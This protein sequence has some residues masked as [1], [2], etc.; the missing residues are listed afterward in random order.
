MIKVLFFVY[1]A[2]KSLTLFSDKFRTG[3]PWVDAMIDEFL[4]HSEISLGLAVPIS[5]QKF[6]SLT[7]DQ[8]TLYGLPDIDLNR[9]QRRWLSRGQPKSKNNVLLDHAL[10]AV[11]DFHPD[12]IQIFGTENKF[13]KLCFKVE[14]PIVIHFQGSVGAV[15][16]KWFSGIS[17]WEQLRS[18]TLKNA[19]FQHGVYNEFFNFSRKTHMEEIVMQKCK[20]YIG[21][22]EFDRRLISLL[23]P[24]SRY[25]SCDEFI[26]DSFFTTQ[27]N[28]PLNKSIRC[29]SI[30]KGV[31]YKGIDLLYSCL[32]LIDKY[33]GID[34]EFRICG[35]NENDEIVKILKKK[36]RRYANRAKIRFLGKLSS[37]EIIYEL[38]NSNFYVHPSYMENSS[39]SICEAMALGLPVIA[40]NVGGTCS[41]INNGVDGLLIQEGEPYSL[42]ACILELI[43]DYHFAKMLGNNA[44]IR[45]LSR[46]NPDVLAET[47]ITIYNTIRNESRIH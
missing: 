36:Y 11:G 3:F 31:T 45:S 25:F 12:I 20:Y 1:S 16:G 14:I 41:L 27:W 9:S 2:Q 18:L 43:R 13:G 21:R 5:D 19:L 24:N 40:T 17:K 46:H 10:T 7:N 38:T 6:T 44:R 39:N 22:T 42:V 26:R 32:N 15:A 28:L 29:S 35:V 4:K 34:F 33:I 8:L 23:S 30:L 37:E 47:I